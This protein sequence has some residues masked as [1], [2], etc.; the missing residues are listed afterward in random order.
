MSC[1]TS[2]TP[3]HPTSLSSTSECPTHRDEGLRAIEQIR[4]RDSAVGVLVLSHY[5]E[6]GYAI[7]LLQCAPRAVGYLVKDRVQDTDRLFDALRRRRAR[8]SSTLT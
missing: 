4:A 5:A 3:G 1:S 2:S 7:R 6:T 8:S